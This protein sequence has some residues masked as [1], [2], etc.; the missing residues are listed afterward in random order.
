[1]LIDFEKDFDSANWNFLFKTLEK[2]N[3]GKNYINYEKTMC[4]KIEATVLNNGSTSSYFKLEP[5]VR[6][7]CP[8]SAY[9]FL[10]VIETL[11][12]E[13]WNDKSIEGIRIDKK[14]LK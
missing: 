3:L 10:V 7:G 11:A 5:G 9:L 4:N 1:M 12:N 13:I 6:Q 8:L 14:K 2:I